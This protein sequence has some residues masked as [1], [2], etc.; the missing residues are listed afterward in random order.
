MSLSRHHLFVITLLAFELLARP[1]FG[2]QVPTPT[3]SVSSENTFTHQLGTKALDGAIE[4]GL[5]FSRE[6]GQPS[7]NWPVHGFN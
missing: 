1:A 2:Q 7:G 3:V 4:A 6:N 5:E